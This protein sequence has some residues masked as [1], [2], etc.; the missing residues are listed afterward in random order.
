MRFAKAGLLRWTSHRDLA[1]LWERIVRRAALQLSMTEGF[2]PKP[3][4]GFPSALALG[5]N[6]LDEVVE[7]ELAEKMPVAELFQRLCDDNQPGL[8]IKSVKL[9]PEGFGKAQLSRSDYVITIP[10]SA[11]IDAAQQAIAE[12][13]LKDTVS[14]ERKQKT[15]TVETAQIPSIEIVGDELHLSL[16]ASGSASLRPGDVLDLINASDWIEHGAVISRTKVV[17]QKE[18]EAETPDQIAIASADENAPSK[19]AAK[20]TS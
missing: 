4:I 14:F 3:R 13:K 10:D 16:A 15:V 20:A 19:C 2:H 8:R 18:F 1:R 9:L 6:G 17:L 7:L 11:D 12:L 5:V